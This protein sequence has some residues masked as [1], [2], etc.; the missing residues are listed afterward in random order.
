METE[1][2]DAIVRN[3]LHAHNFALVSKL[4]VPENVRIFSVPVPISLHPEQ[5]QYDHIE[6][7]ADDKARE[8][9]TCAARSGIE[10]PVIVKR[11][12]THGLMGTSNIH[13]QIMDAPIVHQT[14]RR[15]FDNLKAHNDMKLPNVDRPLNVSDFKYEQFTYLIGLNC[16]KLESVLGIRGAE[17]LSLEVDDHPLLH[18]LT[19]YVRYKHD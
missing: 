15:I 2:L 4:N 12:I 8:I 13:L 19:A 18:A 10:A 16:V 14:Y 3:L 11:S 7:S 6:L 17:I 5:A 9:A 1:Y